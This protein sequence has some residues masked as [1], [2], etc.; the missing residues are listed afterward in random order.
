M[1][2]FEAFA[3]LIR[4]IFNC[5]LKPS[6]LLRVLCRVPRVPLSTA[7][8]VRSPARAFVI[9]CAQRVNLCADYGM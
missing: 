5:Q 3:F 2:Q 6:R 8:I 7:R 9:T 4:I 1:S